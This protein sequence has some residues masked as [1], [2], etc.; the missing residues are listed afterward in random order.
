[1]TQTAKIYGDSLYD[2]AAEASITESIFHQAQEVETLLR[3]NPDYVRLLS[4]PSLKLEERLA[5][6]D[7]AFGEEI[8]VYLLNFMK[9]LCERGL[10]GEIGGCLQ[11][12]RLRYYK[13]NHIAQATVTSAIALTETQRDALRAQL[14]KISGKQILLSE[15]V[16]PSVIGGLR[17]EMEGKLINGTVAGRLSELHKKIKENVT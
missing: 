6:L 5:L 3:E 13:D 10:L 11:E 9:L 8:E 14:E 2:L 4:E 12:Y 7:Q 17:I 15:K 1:M 16:Q